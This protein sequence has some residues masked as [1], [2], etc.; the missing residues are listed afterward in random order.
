MCICACSLMH[1][2]FDFGAESFW[3]GE[4]AGARSERAPLLAVYK[5][6]D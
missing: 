1:Q 3:C 5:Y 4:A 2:C 6:E